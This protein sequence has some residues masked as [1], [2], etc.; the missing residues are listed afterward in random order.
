M[1]KILALIALAGLALPSLAADQA[2]AMD[3][4]KKNGC[5]A[6]HALDKKL[7]GPAWNEVGKKYAG[8]PAA[9]EQLVVK[10]KKGTKGT[11]GAVPMPPNATVKDTD[12]KV[13]VDFVLT[14]K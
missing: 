1:K 9:A 2:T 4:A 6:C 7:V 10:V 3:I 5:L 14:L 13:L 11:W 8:D 12:I